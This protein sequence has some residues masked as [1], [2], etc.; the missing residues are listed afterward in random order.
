M[1]DTRWT[2]YQH[3]Q[4]VQT[5]FTLFS[6]DLWTERY[7]PTRWGWQFLEGFNK[8]QLLVLLNYDKVYDSWKKNKITIITSRLSIFYFVCLGLVDGR[9]GTHTWQFVGGFNKWKSTCKVEMCAVSHGVRW[10]TG[11][12]MEILPTRLWILTSCGVLI[13]AEQT[14]EILR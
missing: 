11:N 1:Y 10:S 7:I 14:I 6:K 5:Y 3:L 8:S 13:K 9:K 4:I 12:I 2:R